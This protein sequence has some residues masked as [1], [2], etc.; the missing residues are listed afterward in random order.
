MTEDDDVRKIMNALEMSE[1]AL[2]DEEIAKIAEMD[3]A[4]VRHGL[5][6]LVF[7]DEITVEV[8]YRV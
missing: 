5:R 1:K 3:I 7:E 6:R 2:T 8:R 4:Y